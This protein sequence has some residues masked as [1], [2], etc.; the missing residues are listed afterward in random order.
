MMPKP[1]ELVESFKINS[2]IW[3]ELQ[4]QKV[5]LK[6]QIDTL[7]NDFKKKKTT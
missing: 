2:P 1:Q 6:T 4:N 3:K 7:E 5:N